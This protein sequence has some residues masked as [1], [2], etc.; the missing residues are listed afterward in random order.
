M[1]ARAADLTNRFLSRGYKQEW[2]DSA[3][4]RFESISQ[5]ECLNPV[6]R[7]Q[8]KDNP[9]LC[10]TIY[11]SMG[12][13][14]RKI[15]HNHWHIIDTD[16][17]LKAVFKEPPKLVFRRSPNLRDQLIRS[18]TPPPIPTTFLSNT[19]PGNYK[20]SNCAQCGYTTKCTTFTHPHSGKVLNIKG[21]IS[22]STTFVVYLIKC[23]CGLAYIGKTTRALRTRIS[24]HRSNIRC[25]DMSKPVAAHF[26]K[27]GHSITSLRYWGI[28]KVDRPPRGGDHNRLLLQRESFYIYAL[29]TMAPHELNEEFDVKPFL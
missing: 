8:R 7:P 1:L 20:C 4:K 11:S 21:V 17:K 13:E 12:F 19:S 3:V 2:V 14:L 16:P 27:M 9:P 10:I 15:L 5:E 23:P 28:E 6:K 26:K 24:E 22:C 29:N 18:Y 25:G